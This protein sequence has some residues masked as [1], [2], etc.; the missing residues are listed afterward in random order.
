MLIRKQASLL[1]A[2]RQADVLPDR[3]VRSLTPFF[4]HIRPTLKVALNSPTEEWVCV[5]ECVYVCVNVRE[6]IGGHRT[7][8][9]MYLDIW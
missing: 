7:D 8:R 2:V 3:G 6:M 1:L 9:G 4:C 5:Y